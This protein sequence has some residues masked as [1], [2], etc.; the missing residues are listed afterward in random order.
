MQI[1][2]SPT[3]RRKIDEIVDYISADNLDAAMALIES[4]EERVKHLKNH[5]ESGRIASVLNDEMVREIVAHPNYIP[6]YELKDSDIII[7][8]IR[9]SKQHKND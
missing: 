6:V 3:A 9:H 2:W 5:P 7:L 8:T 1:I 4:F